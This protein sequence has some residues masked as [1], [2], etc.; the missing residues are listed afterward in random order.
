LWKNLFVTTI[1]ALLFYQSNQPHILLAERILASSRPIPELVP[2]TIA[3]FA[4]T[5]E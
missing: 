1:K 5:P 2:T 3:F 4:K